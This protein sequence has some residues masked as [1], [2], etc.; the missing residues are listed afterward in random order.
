M[1]T[2]LLSWLFPRTMPALEETGIR[3]KRLRLSH[4]T[5]KC[6]YARLLRG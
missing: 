3:L 4:P 6:C 5:T 2:R 1:I